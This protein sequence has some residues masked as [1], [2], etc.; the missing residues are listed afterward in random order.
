MADDTRISELIWRADNRTAIKSMVQIADQSDKTKKTLVA[1]ATEES[2]SMDRVREHTMMLRDA[3]TSLMGTIGIAGVAF[4]LKDLVVDGQ[5]LQLSQA[6]L[7][8]ALR[9]TGQD[10][11]STADELQKL[12]ESMSVKGGFSITENMSSLTQ[13][14]RE[15]KSAT[16]AQ[17]L[18]NLASNIARATGQ[19]LSDTT[20]V[21]AKAYDGQAR[22]LQSLL[23]P[24][25]AAKDAS[26]GLS[27]AH[28]KEIALIQE[29]ASLLSGPAKT[30]YEQQAMLADHITAQQSEAAAL[31]DKQITAQQLL[32]RATSEFAGATGKYSKT[33]EGQQSNLQH[34]INNLGESIGRSLVPE[35]KFLVGVATDVADWMEKDK[36]EVEIATIAVG[37][38]VAAWGGMKILG[39]IKTM[40]LDLG[41]AFGIAGDEGFAGGRMA[42]LGADEAA[43]AWK[44]FMTTTILGLVVVGLVELIE[45]WKQVEAVATAVWHGI[46]GAAVDMWHAIV[47]GAKFAFKEIKAGLHDLGFT[48]NGIMSYINPMGLER[49]ALG[50]VGSLFNQ[51][52]VV[53][54]Y[55]ALGG[56][57]TPM[58]TDT[59]PTMLSP[60]EGVVSA[61]GMDMLS[62]INSGQGFGAGGNLT[63]QAAPFVLRTTDRDL[64]EAVLRFFVNRGARGSTSLVGGALAISGVGPTGS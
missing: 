33:V 36:T 27:V 30:A 1:G 34:S 19:S 14:V 24:M 28:Q 59:V 62:S 43:V 10:A 13:F 48:G 51:G 22:G 61:Q 53:P 57:M 25:V 52:G 40:V 38:L 39:G 4:G 46:E 23:G 41:K 6:Q 35:M 60:G 17:K 42:A 63:I 47:A 37:G 5:K 7:Q 64:G 50:A 31:S 29:R 44:A 49:H 2:A 20:A 18:F 15:T 32:T 12:A 58:G 26:V 54:E 21:V 9:D 56:M 3:M 16:E 45:H 11:G 8:S 55:R